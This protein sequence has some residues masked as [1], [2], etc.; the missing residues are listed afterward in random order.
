MDQG[1]KFDLQELAQ[2]I[3]KAK[4]VREKE[5]YQAIAYRIATESAPIQSL[6]D[7]LIRAF[8]ARDMTKVKK[9]QEHIQYIKMGETYGKSWGSMK[10]NR[11]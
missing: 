7:E 3:D 1:R 4:S 11:L 5:H 2:A 6:R 8:R 10:G 9:I